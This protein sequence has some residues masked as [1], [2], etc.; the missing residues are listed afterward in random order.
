MTWECFENMYAALFRPLGVRDGIEEWQRFASSVRESEVQ[1]LGNAMRKCGCYLARKR[2]AGA[3]PMAP[4][5]PDI[6]LWFRQEKEEQSRLSEQKKNDCKLCGGSGKL[7]VVSASGWY[8]K[9]VKFPIRPEDL[10]KE[11]FNGFEVWNCPDCAESYSNSDFANALR[12]AGYP[13]STPTCILAGRV[14]ANCAESK[15]TTCKN[16]QVMLH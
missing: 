10:P 4:R 9:Q 5:I 8:R 16:R 6:A 15:E 3:D 11:F 7:V 2:L 12:E 13:D 14:G 1:I